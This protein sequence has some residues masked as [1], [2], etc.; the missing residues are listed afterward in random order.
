MIIE[1]DWGRLSQKRERVY[2]E[3]CGGAKNFCDLVMA[4]LSAIEPPCLEELTAI[5]YLMPTML[6][7]MTWG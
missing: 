5:I 3:R 4:G 1:R 7:K 2:E 6:A